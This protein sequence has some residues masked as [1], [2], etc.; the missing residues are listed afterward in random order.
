MEWRRWI[1]KGRSSIRLE[2]EA[3]STVAADGVESGVVVEVLQKGYRLGRSVDPAGSCGG[4]R[5]GGHGR[6]PL[7]DA[8]R[9]QGSLRGGDQEGVPEAGAQVSPRPQSG[10]PEG[11]GEVQGGPGGLRHALGSR[12]AQGVR[13]GRDVRWVRR[14]G[15]T[16]GRP[17]RAGRWAAGGFD[18]SDIFSLFGRGGGRRGRRPQG[19]R[20]RDL[21]TEIS[22]SFDQAV[23]GAQVDVTVP[24][25]E[26]CPTC[27]GSG[28]KPG[29][30]PVTC[31]RCEGAASTRRARA[32]SR[33]ASPARSAAV[34]ARSSRTP[35]RPAAA[36]A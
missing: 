17:V 20:G 30:S 27:H 36:A 6:G 31:P 22:L 23:N 33:S 16:R 13:R 4:E 18:V 5:V 10:R 24:K 35:A 1:R 34:P 25:A 3:L 8:G 32:S 14:G 28:A 12:E 9:R 29:T 11:R 7:Q 21:E 2:H 15:R 26:R 19:A